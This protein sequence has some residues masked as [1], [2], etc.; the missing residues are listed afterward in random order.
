MTDP[1]PEDCIEAGYSP[2][3]DECAEKLSEADALPNLRSSNWLPLLLLA[4]LIAAF[5]IISGVLWVFKLMANV[6]IAVGGAV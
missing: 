5:V 1:Y 3:C 4:M 6:A 2:V